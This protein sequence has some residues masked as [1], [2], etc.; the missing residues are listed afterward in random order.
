M[1]IILELTRDE[2]HLLNDLI[3]QGIKVEE[4]M[5]HPTPD[6]YQALA[7]WNDAYQEEMSK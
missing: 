7:T 2:A 5:G 1:K 3:N 6:V 4:N